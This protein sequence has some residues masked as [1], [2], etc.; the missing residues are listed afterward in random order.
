MKFSIIT[1]C[2]NASESIGVTIESVLKQKHDDY[3][4]II[5]DGASEDGTMEILGAYSDAHMKVFSEADNG[6]SSAFNKGIKAARGDLFL[7][8]NCGDI[9]IRDD[10]LSLVESD[11]NCNIADIYTYAICTFSNPKWPDSVSCG[12]ELWNKSVIPHQAT[13]F[14]KMVFDKVGVFNEN[15]RVRMDYDFFCRCKKAQLIFFCNP[16]PIVHYDLN[17]IS[18]TNK[19]LYEKEGLSVR[20]LY[21]DQVE[22]SEAEK[23]E[24]LIN[25]CILQ[26]KPF[27]ENEISKLRELLSKDTKII[28]LMNKWIECLQCGRNLAEYFSEHNYRTVA[29]YGYGYLGNC[30]KREL[31]RNNIAVPYVIDQNKRGEGIFAWEDDWEIVD[32]IVVTAIGSYKEIREK[33]LRK[34]SFNVMSIED[35]FKEL[36]VWYES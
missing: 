18:S 30:L 9:F 20:L 35:I 8:L 26:S 12:I 19:Y 3:E 31:E 22:Y 1:I 17:G 10:V 15:F 5:I 33:I 2:K 4:H 14:R 21:Q 27:I 25:E 32:C 6:I 23:M 13:F 36:Y 34:R 7:F 11:V 29:I 24:Y 28:Q 16:T